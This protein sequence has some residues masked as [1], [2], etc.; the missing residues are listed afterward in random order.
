MS[1]LISAELEVEVEE[2]ARAAQLTGARLLDE[3]IAD[4]LLAVFGYGERAVIT[5]SI[6]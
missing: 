2:A 6:C 4:L 1:K 3:P 5:A